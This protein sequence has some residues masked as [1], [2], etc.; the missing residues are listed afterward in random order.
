MQTA[1]S[2]GPSGPIRVGAASQRS[3]LQSMVRIV[4]L[5]PALKDAA[6]VGLRTL[7]E[8]P[9]MS[10]IYPYLDDAIGNIEAVQP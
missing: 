6:L 10:S 7:H 2:F 9:G 3:A 1:E 4:R 8:N 5:D